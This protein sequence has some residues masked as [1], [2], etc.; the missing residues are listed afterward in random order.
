M[1][2]YDEV[3]K[4]GRTDVAFQSKTKTKDVDLRLTFC[5]FHSRGDQR[6]PDEY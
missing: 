3:F 6:R 1:F 2:N 4:Q 5:A